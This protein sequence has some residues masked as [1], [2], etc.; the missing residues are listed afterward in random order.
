MSKII[1]LGE[2]LIKFN[3]WNTAGQERFS[4]LITTYY[5]DAVAAIWC[6]M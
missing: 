6:M 1:Q 5:K 3:I 4:N 2:K